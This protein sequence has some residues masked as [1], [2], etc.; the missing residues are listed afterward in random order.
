MTGDP[1]DGPVIVRPENGECDITIATTLVSTNP[2]HT[3]KLYRGQILSVD[4]EKN[5]LR[6]KEVYSLVCKDGDVTV[7]AVDHMDAETIMICIRKK[8]KYQAK[9][10]QVSGGIVRVDVKMI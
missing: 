3:Q 10:V 2:D 4:I 7:G 1:D 5:T 6:D 8:K 9:I